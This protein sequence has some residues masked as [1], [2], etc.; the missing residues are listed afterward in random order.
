MPRSAPEALSEAGIKK[1]RELMKSDHP[2]EPTK[3]GIPYGKLG[4]FLRARGFEV[5]VSLGPSEMEARFL[6]LRDGSTVGKVP[7]LFSL[8]HASGLD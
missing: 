4:E 3:F 7:V 5:I 2:G 8:V 1:L 6:T